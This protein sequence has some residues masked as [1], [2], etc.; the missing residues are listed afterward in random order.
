MSK[1]R[2]RLW[3]WLIVIGILAGLGGWF[4]TRPKPPIEV[5]TAQ[6]ERVSELKAIVTASG[7][8]QAHES[9]DIQA[10]I[11]G[12]IIELAVVEGQRVTKGQLL[13]RIDPLQMQTEVEAAR[14]SH[15]AALAE[16]KGMDARIAAGQANIAR[17]KALVD[18]ARVDLAQTE[19]SAKRARSAFERTRKLFEKGLVPDEEDE[20]A[21]AE[22]KLA[23]ARVE[24]ATS[25]VA[26]IEAQQKASEIALEEM[27]ASRDAA[28]QRAAAA[29]AAFDR[30][31]DLLK[32]TKIESPLD[33]VITHL[34]VEVGERAVPGILS[35]P[36]ATL[37]TIADLSALEAEIDVD[38]TDIV[39]VRLGHP[40]EVV[41]DAMEDTTFIGEV[42]EIANAP[43]TASSL[44]ATQ[45]KDFEVTA[46]L[47]EPTAALA[48]L[49]PGMSCEAKIKTDTRRDVLVI[50]IQALVMREVFVGDAGEFQGVVPPVTKT[51]P[52]GIAKA[53]D[54]KGKRKT[55]ERQGI[56]VVEAGG[57]ARFRPVRIGIYGEMEVEVLEGASEGD[58]VII[59]PQRVLRTIFDG[60]SVRGKPVIGRLAREEEDRDVAR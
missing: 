9:V 36:Q 59:G 47:R 4:F 52:G 5:L 21:E 60:Q 10:E 24:A 7:E 2:R 40:A 3:K 20:I 17:D 55:E 41:V 48:S 15:A 57:N 13:L 11:A 53:A 58:T 45:G 28:L 38:E 25:K 46:R 29:K 42:T 16:S 23:D 51:E 22:A 50:P 39:K 44:S 8:I 27:G 37:M 49:R 12:V 14:A 30:A 33:G 34:N 18:A 35:N 43:K 32:K 6:A 1:R 31:D 54:E 19:V 56:F 26:Q